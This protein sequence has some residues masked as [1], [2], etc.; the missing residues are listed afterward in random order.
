MNG[1]TS[2]QDAATWLAYL[3]RVIACGEG[4]TET[5]RITGDDAKLLAACLFARSISTARAIV[6]LI[7]LGHVVE[8]RMLARSIFEN[9]FF[10]YRLARDDGSAFASKMYAD[11]AFYRRVL[12]ETMLKEKQA[13][14]AMGEENQARV[15]AVIK[16][17][18]KKNPNATPLKPQD[19]ISG[20]DISYASIFYQQLSSDA[21]HPS[22]TAL[23]RHFDEDAGPD[24]LS[25]KP[26][27]K[28]REVMNTAFLTSKALLYACIS[29]NTAFGGTTGG[30][31][32]DGLVAEHNEIEAR[33][34][35]A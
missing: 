1:A 33:P 32:L 23:K 3:D 26:R 10:L 31:R 2:N 13:R 4:I 7:G 16:R 5:A 27:I 15:R 30:E 6:H 20:A 12:G 25:L 17:S 14:E 21:G 24:G 18:N 34:L 29:A 22:V 9:W 19:V 8:A 11:E 28:G 35:S